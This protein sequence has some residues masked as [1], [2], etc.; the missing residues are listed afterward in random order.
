[1]GQPTGKGIRQPPLEPSRQGAEQS[2]TTAGHTGPS[3]S[4]MEEPAMVPH[5]TGHAGGLPNPHPTQ[6]GSDHT[7]TPGGC[8]S[9]TASTSRMAYLRQRFQ[10]KEIS[11]EGT[12]LLLASWRQKSSK[13]YDSL[14]GKWV[15]WC[16][17]RHSDPVSGPIS[18][19]VNFLAHL[20]K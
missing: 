12:E 15:D 10:S 2:T 13:S 18:E 7:N 4:S 9:S 1:M 5:S 11:E 17:Q 14:F 6:G 16:N 8:T 20:L 3:G 19:V